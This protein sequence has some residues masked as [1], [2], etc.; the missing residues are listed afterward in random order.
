[1]NHVPPGPVTTPGY[2]V[3]HYQDD[4]TIHAKMKAQGKKFCII[5]ADEG[6]TI[7]DRLFKAHYAAAKA[8][9]MIVGFYNFFHPAQD[10][11]KQAAH[12]LGLIGPLNND[13]GAICDLESADK[14]SPKAVGDEAYLFLCD[15]KKAMGQAT[16]YGS[17]Y[18]LRDQAK[19]DSR[20]NAFL[21][22]I[23]EY[24][25]PAKEGPLLPDGLSKWDFWQV[26]ETGGLDLNVFNGSLD[27]L[28]AL[29]L[30]KAA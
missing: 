22:W 2:D 24:G 20:F 28:E 21:I 25:L 26:S 5:K 29:T 30:K 16:L 10:P 12:I 18:F 6:A 9:G 7:V 15:V 13:L 14:V 4:M 8:A 11:H 19:V 3:S 27:Q 1:M 23:A 17:P